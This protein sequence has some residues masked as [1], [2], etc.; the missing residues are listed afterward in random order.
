MAT[1]EK[2]PRKKKTKAKEIDGDAIAQRAYE[3]SLSA[4]AASDVE[5]WLRAESE[6]RGTA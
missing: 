1:T 5:N 4:D 2:A 6:L 3:I